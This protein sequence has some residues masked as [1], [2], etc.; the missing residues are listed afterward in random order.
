MP[1]YPHSRYASG[2]AVRLA[3]SS[4]VYNVTVLR[5]VPSGASG[6]TLYTWANGDRPDTVAQKLLGNPTLWWAIFDINPNMI[7]PMNVPAGTLVRI[8]LGPVQGQGTLIQ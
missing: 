7:D 5:S 3:N 4:S 6:Y 1:I 2:T 8:P